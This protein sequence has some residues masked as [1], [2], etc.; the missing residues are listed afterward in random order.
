MDELVKVQKKLN[1]YEI[2]LENCIVESNRI[3]TEIHKFKH[4]LDK[5]KHKLDDFRK[6][7]EESNKELINEQ[8]NLDEFDAKLNKIRVF[9]EGIEQS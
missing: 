4:S 2:A 6:Q 7:L 1:D 8:I 3:T 5:F 9:I